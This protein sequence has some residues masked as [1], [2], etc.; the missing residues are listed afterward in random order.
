MRI[1]SFTILNIQLGYT[2]VEDPVFGGDH[3]FK[4]GLKGEGSLTIITQREPCVQVWDRGHVHLE[5]SSLFQKCEI[6]F[7]GYLFATVHRIDNPRLTHSK[8]LRQKP[9][10]YANSLT[11]Q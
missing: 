3:F 6:S 2:P 7:S 11:T 8:A 10:I 5:I 1:T 9:P 4:N